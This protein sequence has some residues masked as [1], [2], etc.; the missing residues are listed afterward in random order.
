MKGKIYILG[1][2]GTATHDADFTKG[3]GEDSFEVKEM[4]P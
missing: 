1:T 3:R 4:K 2:R